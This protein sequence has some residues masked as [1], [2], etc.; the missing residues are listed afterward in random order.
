MSCKENRYW[1]IGLIW[2]MLTGC[3]QD[4][5]FISVSFHNRSNENISFY[6]YPK[7]SEADTLLSDVDISFKLYPNK[8]VGSLIDNEHLENDK[9]ICLF[10]LNYD[11]I[12]KY[13]WKKVR[14]DYLIIKR[15]DLT[16]EDIKKMNYAITYP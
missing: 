7:V 2:I 8:I 14:D 12:S 4:A 9:S 6:F 1:I 15:Y 16:K 13:G 5:D 10:I 3:P 11:T